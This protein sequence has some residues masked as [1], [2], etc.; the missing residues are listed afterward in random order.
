MGTKQQKLAMFRLLFELSSRPKKTRD[1]SDSEWEYLGIVARTLQISNE[2]AELCI[3]EMNNIFDNLNIIH[4]LFQVSVKNYR[5]ISNATVG[6]MITIYSYTEMLRACLYYKKEPTREEKDFCD[7]IFRNI[8]TSIFGY[9]DCSNLGDS[10]YQNEIKQYEG[11]QWND[12]AE[13]FIFNRE[14]SSEASRKEFTEK[15]VSLKRGSNVKSKVMDNI[16]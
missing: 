11:A 15:F 4:K 1:L 7:V 5:G 6:E 2:E 13:M 12:I 10:F 9:Y 14:I 16:F 8:K 3:N